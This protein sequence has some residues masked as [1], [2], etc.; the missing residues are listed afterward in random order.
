MVVPV[1]EVDCPHPGDGDVVTGPA[2]VVVYDE[3]LGL[4]TSAAV[5]RSVTGGQ[6]LTSILAFGAVYC[7]LG[8][9]WLWVLNHKIRE[10]PDLPETGRD[11]PGRSPGDELTGFLDAAAE[12]PANKQSLTEAKDQEGSP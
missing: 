5:S 6:V 2:G 7:L 1:G 11:K 12:R 10:G 8:V 9:I 3:K 4:R